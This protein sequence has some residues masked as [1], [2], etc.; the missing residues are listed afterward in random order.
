MFPCGDVP[1]PSKE[2]TETPVKLTI[3]SLPLLAVSLLGHLLA[4]RLV[5]RHDDAPLGLLAT[6]S[7][8]TG[9]PVLPGGPGFEMVPW[10]IALIEGLFRMTFLAAYYLSG[11]MALAGLVGVAAGVV[12]V[13]DREEL[14]ARV[15]KTVADRRV[16]GVVGAELVLWTAL[17]EPLLLDLLVEVTVILATAATVFLLCGAALFLVADRAS[18]RQTVAVVYPLGGLTVVLPPIA[19]AL[20]SPAFGA[21]AR[22]LTFGLAVWLI[23]T[24]LR[25]LGLDVAVQRLFDL[26][27][28]GF[29]LL[30]G[31]LVVGGSWVAGVVQYY[32]G[33]V[34][35][36]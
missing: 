24:V 9:A 10:A 17:F 3:V 26:A 6:P 14:V 35:S 30:W 5:A 23:V 12:L 29:I 7:I 25:P 8:S 11:A 13:R 4:R 18:P 1:P 32:R 15:R 2:G 21:V 28:P 34:A 20:A 33:T 27:G 16:L 19:A 22:D 36:D 31:S